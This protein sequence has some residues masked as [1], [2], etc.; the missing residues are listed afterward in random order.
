M[1]YTR[2]GATDIAIPRLCI[3]GMSFGKV[4]PDFHQWVIDQEATQAVIARALELGVNFIDTAN[5]YAHGT[6]EEFI[7]ASLK[8]LGIKREDVVLASKVYFNEGHLS[9]AAIEREIDGTLERLGTDYLDLYI[10]HRFDYA[11]PVEETL[12]AL[13][14]LVCSGRVRALG[15]CPCMPTSCT[16]CR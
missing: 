12:E 16:P 14:A 6:S 13:D 8:N 15:R 9:R 10:I 1:E 11:T 2:L 3:G 7:G 4:F 5:V